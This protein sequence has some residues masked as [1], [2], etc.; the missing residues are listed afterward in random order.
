MDEFLW[1]LGLTGRTYD[2]LE[3]VTLGIY[4]QRTPMELILRKYCL[5]VQKYPITLQEYSSTS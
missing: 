4:Q 2:V 5:Q 3:A 1:D